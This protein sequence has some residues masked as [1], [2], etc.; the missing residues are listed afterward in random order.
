[1]RFRQGISNI[2]SIVIAA[3]LLAACSANQAPLSKPTGLP[4]VSP[5]TI[6]TRS[7]TETVIPSPATISSPSPAATRDQA[8]QEKLI[9]TNQ[10]SCPIT[11]AP[12]IE[13][14]AIL[15]LGPSPGVPLSKA[16]GDKLVILGTVYAD[17][18]TPLAGANLEVHQ[19]DPN[20]EYGPGHGTDQLQCCYLQ[21]NVQTDD[22]GHYQLITVRP[23]HYKNSPSPVP[24]AH[25]HLQVSSPG[26]KPFQGEIVFADDPNLMSVGSDQIVTTLE[27]AASH[28][29]ESTYLRG[30][31]DLV[32][33]RLATPTSSASVGSQGSR[34][35]Q[36]MPEASEAAY[37]IHE[38]FSIIPVVTSAV[39]TT[40]LV[41]G[42]LQIHF[43]SSVTIEAL[44][45]KVD[46]RG[47]K[48]DERNRD[49]KL[50]DQWLV[51]DQYPYAYFRAGKVPIEM[52]NYT[53]GEVATFTL[54]GEVTIRDKTRSV[55]FE[56][57]AKVVGDTLTGSAT[58]RLKMSDFGINPPN[59]LDFVKVEDEVVLTVNITGKDTF[60]G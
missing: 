33:I 42:T 36:I 24:P 47:L 57:S 28:E 54:T 3:V 60:G 38:K 25:I 40:R 12:E 6:P 45:I 1:M 31:A 8:E 2:L 18:C 17:D 53:E 48:S 59:L 55:P 19:T 4:T 49:N 5:T 30:V 29:G 41:E 22:N 10:T 35:F 11:Q 9:G 16:K 46:L 56:I 7:P 52:I 26:M 43:G 51:T 34:T 14:Q 13:P 20:G 50:A 21:G 23:G 15:T 27:M 44:E 58:G 37:Q 39:G 32:L